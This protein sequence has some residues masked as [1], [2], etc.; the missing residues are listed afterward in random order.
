MT[1]RIDFSASLGLDGC[2]FCGKPLVNVAEETE[3]QRLTVKTIEGEA[4]SST[5]T[6]H[7][8]RNGLGTGNTS[9]RHL[10][11]P[12]RRSCGGDDADAGW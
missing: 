11:C 10:A 5:I 1:G 8:F 3:K 2:C 7:A 12:S 9:P 4:L 6:K